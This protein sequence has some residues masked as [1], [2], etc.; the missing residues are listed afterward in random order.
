M[1]QFPYIEH[2]PW[3]DYSVLTLPLQTIILSEVIPIKFFFLEYY[4]LSDH[5]YHILPSQNTILSLVIHIKS[6]LS[7]IISSVSSFILYSSFSEFIC[8]SH[9]SPIL[10]VQNMTYY[11]SIHFS[12]T[13]LLQI[14]YHIIHAYDTF[15]SNSHFIIWTYLKPP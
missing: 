13:S 6:V 5:R 15:K 8:L 11:I 9:S 14:W 4:P 7:E 12:V 10:L 3:L 1:S 2:Y